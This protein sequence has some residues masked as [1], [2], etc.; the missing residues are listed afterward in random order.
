MVF[1]YLNNKIFN[2]IL[3]LHVSIF[4]INLFKYY[5]YFFIFLIN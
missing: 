4:I 1:K 2:I 5:I 3:K